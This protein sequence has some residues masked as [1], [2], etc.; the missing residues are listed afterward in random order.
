MQN[1]EKSARTKQK[2]HLEVLRSALLLCFALDVLF[3]SAE[4]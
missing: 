4:L 3:G 2:M 1:K